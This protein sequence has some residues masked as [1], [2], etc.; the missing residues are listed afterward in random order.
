MMVALRNLNFSLAF[1][2]NKL[3]LGYGDAVCDVL[4]FLVDVALKQRDFKWQQ[5]VSVSL[6][7][8][9]MRAPHFVLLTYLRRLCTRTLER[10][11]LYV[12]SLD[13]SS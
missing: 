8:T 9:R 2:V 1:P 3:R 6:A 5:P 10:E 7:H 12:N 11:M 13:R 4:D